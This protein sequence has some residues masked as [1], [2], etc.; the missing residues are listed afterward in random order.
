MK[1][2]KW[3]V[4]GMLVCLFIG[5]ES[6]Q[7]AYAGGVTGVASEWTQLLNWAQLLEENS[8]ELQALENSFT[9]IQ[10]A[11]TQIQNQE[12]LIG[13]AEQQTTS[14]LNVMNNPVF[15]DALTD[16]N[17]L[18]NI[19][20]VGNG[21]AYSMA[22]MD[23]EFTNRFKGFGYTNAANYPGQYQ[24]WMQT[25]LDTTH[26][27]LLAVGVQGQQ[28]PSDT[29][30]LAQ[31]QAQ[32]ASTTGMLQTVQVANEL[33]GQEVLELQKLRQIMLADITSKQAFQ[34]QQISEGI[35]A[36]DLNN[37]FFSNPQNTTNSD[38]RT[39]SPIPQY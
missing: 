9:D 17:K 7:P 34:A 6:V 31:I 25:S 22:N 32:A 35:A 8:T 20:Q 30:V 19:I 26:G 11:L 24:S 28:L 23:T 18:T 12:T 39:F 2:A 33:A 38:S 15:K 5:G 1:S 13:H 4:I 16:M 37:T 3:I 27:A 21:L 36:S 29:Q 14:L 10:N